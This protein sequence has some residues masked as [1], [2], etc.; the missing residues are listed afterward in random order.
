MLFILFT[1]HLPYSWYQHRR[2]CL[3]GA[4][5][6][7]H[8]RNEHSSHEH[9]NAIFTDKN[10]RVVA[11]CEPKP[12]TQLYLVEPSRRWKPQVLWS[13]ILCQYFYIDLRNLH[14]SRRK[15]TVTSHFSCKRVCHIIFCQ[16]DVY[17]LQLILSNTT[18][19]HDIRDN[20]L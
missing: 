5:S 12:T 19:L 17:H 20:F 15:Q 13:W 18:K 7:F 1:K 16:I 14:S 11:P 6:D 2:E 9:S 8:L 3:I 4:R 10:S